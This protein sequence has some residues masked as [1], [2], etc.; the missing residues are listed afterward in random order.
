VKKDHTMHHQLKTWPVFFQA[1][2]EG[3]KTFEIRENDRGFQVGDTVEL[4]EYDPENPN[5]MPFSGRKIH[6]SIAYLT[7]FAQQQNYVVFSLKD[8]VSR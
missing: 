8:I 5:G 7:D 1:I 6:A 2:R 3:R 4:I